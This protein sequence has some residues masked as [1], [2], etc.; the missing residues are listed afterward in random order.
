MVTI[1]V[2]VIKEKGVI[3]RG[4]TLP[5]KV[6]STASAED[7]RLAAGKKHTLFNSRFIHLQSE[8]ILAFKYGSEVKHIPPDAP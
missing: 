6:P 4:E 1:N 2:G 8:Y 3:K 5:L 7:I